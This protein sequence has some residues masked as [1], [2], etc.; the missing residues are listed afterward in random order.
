MQKSEDDHHHEGLDPHVWLSVDM[1]KVICQNIKEQA[2]HIDSKNKKLY[3]KNYESFIKELEQ[4]DDEIKKTLKRSKGKKFIVFHPSFG[5]FAREYGLVQV[6]IEKEGKEPSLRYLKK[7]ID[8][9]KK[10]DIKVIFAS[11]Q[12]SQKS[13][14]MVAKQIGGVVKSINPLS[15]EWKNNLMNVAKS[16]EKA[17]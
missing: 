16:F 9:A 13:A 6:A 11:P 3:V 2:V 7:I 12:F 8:F 10:E 5:Y 14:S 4:L 17:N 1:V 15:F